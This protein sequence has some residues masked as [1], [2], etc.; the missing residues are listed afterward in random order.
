MMDQLSID[1]TLGKIG[2]DEYIIANSPF[3]LG[4]VSFLLLEFVTGMVAFLFAPPKSGNVQKP[5]A[6]S[7]IASLF[8]VALW[9]IIM[10]SNWLASLSQYGSHTSVRPSE[11]A[12][13]CMVVGLIVF[14][15]AVCALAAVAGGW[16]AELAL[17]Q[18]HGSNV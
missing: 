7:I 9:G 10:L 14:E 4:V 16:L 2:I 11:P 3:F 1:G 6:A 17:Q 5:Y 13:P 15:I 12:L 18:N 8:P